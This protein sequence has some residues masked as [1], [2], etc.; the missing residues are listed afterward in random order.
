MKIEH[1]AWQS[2]DPTAMADWYV[3]HLGMRVVR[4]SGPPTHTHFLEASDGAV[5]IEFYRNEDA[6]IPDYPNQDPLLLHLAFVSEDPAADA[7]RLLEA[8]ATLVSGPEET[9]SGDLLAMLRDPWG[10]PLQFC[11]RKVGG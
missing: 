6:P 9:P 4:A 7:K 8:G 1:V 3:R 10:V 2:P 5:Q 11:K